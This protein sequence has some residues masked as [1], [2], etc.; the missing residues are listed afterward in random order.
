MGIPVV[1]GVHDQRR[2]LHLGKQGPNVD[3][4]GR[5]NI[6]NRNLGRAAEALQLIESLGLFL[7]CGGHHERG[8]YLS[9]SW[10]V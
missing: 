3:I 5:I 2:R 4:V 8:E 10:I 6:S 1:S 7:R 9:K